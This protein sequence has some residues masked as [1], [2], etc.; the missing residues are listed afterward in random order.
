MGHFER[1][2]DQHAH[3]IGSLEAIEHRVARDWEQIRDDLAD[4]LANGEMIKADDRVVLAFGDVTDRLWSLRPEQGEAAIALCARS[5]ELGGR[6]MQRLVFEIAQELVDIFADAFKN[7]L[8][9]DHD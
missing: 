2:A 3:E 8:E 5:P 6:H 7:D 1:Q 4:Q 9:N